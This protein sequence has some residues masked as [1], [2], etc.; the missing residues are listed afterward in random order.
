[1]FDRA[2]RLTLPLLVVA[3][4]VTA[5]AQTTQTEKGNVAVSYGILD[6]S[7]VEETSPTGWVFAVTGHLNRTSR[8]PARLG[9]ATSRST[10]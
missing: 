5:Q 2:L 4:T 9:E 1:M 6:D 7:D 10:C 3:V 8:S